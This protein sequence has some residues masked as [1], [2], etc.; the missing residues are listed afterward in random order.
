MLIYADDLLA[1]AVIKE[2]NCGNKDISVSVGNDPTYMILVS[3]D[4]LSRITAR[5]IDQ[6]FICMYHFKCMC[7]MYRMDSV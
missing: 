3:D 2:K 6:L 1:D 7:M 5:A 4:A